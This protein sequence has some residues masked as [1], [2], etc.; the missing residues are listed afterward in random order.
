MAAELTIATVFCLSDIPGLEYAFNLTELPLQYRAQVFLLASLYAAC[1]ISYERFCVPHVSD[2]EGEPSR[3]KPS[4]GL[5]SCVWGPRSLLAQLDLTL[6]DPPPLSP[7]PQLS[8]QQSLSRPTW[9]APSHA[10]RARASPHPRRRPSRPTPGAVRSLLPRFCCV[11]AARLW[12][13][14]GQGQGRKQFRLSSPLPLSPPPPPHSM[15]LEEMERAE[16]EKMLCS[17]LD[18]QPTLLPKLRRGPPL[19]HQLQTAW[20][21]AEGRSVGRSI[22][23]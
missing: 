20:T 19:Y 23:L 15:S 14:A 16:Q 12:K 3:A 17:C 10:S 5:C 9:L 18:R 13:G 7:V 8:P 11:G 22:A 6:I 4:A 2:D 21:E 1:A